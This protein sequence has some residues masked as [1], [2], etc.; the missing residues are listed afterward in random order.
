LL[1]KYKRNEAHFVSLLTEKEKKKEKRKKKKEKTEITSTDA[2]ARARLYFLSLWRYP[3]S[4]VLLDFLSFF[5]LPPLK[6]KEKQRER[7]E[8]SKARSKRFF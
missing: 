4:T 3:A 5:S 8:K 7:A 1:C 6:T 2:H